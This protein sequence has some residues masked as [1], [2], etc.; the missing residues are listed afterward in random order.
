MKFTSEEA[1]YISQYYTSNYDVMSG[2]NQNA[3]INKKRQ[4]ALKVLTNDLNAIF[5]KGYTSKQVHDKWKNLKKDAKEK[6]QKIKRS[7]YNF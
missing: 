4:L 1:K 2:L 3:D 7:K 5:E 6:Y